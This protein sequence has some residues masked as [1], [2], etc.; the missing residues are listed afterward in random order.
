MQVNTFMYKLDY[1]T[2]ISP[3]CMLFAPFL[4]IDFFKEDKPLASV[5]YVTRTLQRIDQK[6]RS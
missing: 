4:L 6:L 3:A 1:R 5:A 2:S